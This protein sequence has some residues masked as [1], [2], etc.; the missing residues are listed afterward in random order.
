MKIIRRNEEEPTRDE[1]DG[2]RSEQQAGLW[3]TYCFHR[4]NSIRPGRTR[5]AST[6]PSPAQ[7]RN[8][9]NSVNARTIMRVMKDV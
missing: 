6:D 7:R 3:G 8:I 1:G 9:A 4:A 2:R 5:C